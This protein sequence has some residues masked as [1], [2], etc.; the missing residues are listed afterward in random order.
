MYMRTCEKLTNLQV[1]INLYF[2]HASGYVHTL[3]ESLVKPK[4]STDAVVSI[5][6]SS[7]GLRSTCTAVERSE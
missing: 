5:C 3:T 7:D 1:N 6:G 2:V 4:V